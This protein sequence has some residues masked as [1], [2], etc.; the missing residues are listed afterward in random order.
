MQNQP[1]FKFKDKR[2]RKMRG[3]PASTLIPL[4]VVAAAALMNLLL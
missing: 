4:A 1:A 3:I 2:G